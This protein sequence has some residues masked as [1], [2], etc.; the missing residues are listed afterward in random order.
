MVSARA[1]KSCVCHENLA[2][3]SKCLVIYRSWWTSKTRPTPTSEPTTKMHLSKQNVGEPPKIQW[4]ENLH[5]FAIK[6]HTSKLVCMY[7]QTGVGALNPRLLKVVAVLR[8]QIWRR[9]YRMFWKL[10]VVIIPYHPNIWINQGWANKQL[11][12]I[13]SFQCSVHFFSSYPV[14]RRERF[15]AF[16]VFISV[17]N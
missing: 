12:W 8:V 13:S 9:V 10:Q 5:M 6:G 4:F 15:G 7:S 16:G 1:T 17:P 2:S 3:K 11:F 14:V